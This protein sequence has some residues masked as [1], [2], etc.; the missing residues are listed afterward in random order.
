MFLLN[1]EVNN[2]L[3]PDESNFSLK[4]R[5]KNTNSNKLHFEYVA[6]SAEKLLEKSLVEFAKIRL[7]YE[8]TSMYE[9]QFETGYFDD[10]LVSQTLPDLDIPIDTYLNHAL[11]ESTKYIM[12]GYPITQDI[13]KDHFQY[14]VYNDVVYLRR[15]KLAFDELKTGFVR[16]EYDLQFARQP[17]T[18]QL[19]PIGWYYLEEE[20]ASQ[21]QPHYMVFTK[22]VDPENLT[23][24]DICWQEP[25]KSWV[26]SDLREWFYQQHF[27]SIE[28]ACMY[29][30]KTVHGV[31]GWKNEVVKIVNNVKTK[32]TL[33]EFKNLLND[34]S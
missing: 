26:G 9:H 5:I 23:T 11:K 15:Q 1:K 12:M 19:I 4:G 20:T 22:Y 27:E 2:T 28:Q 33:N 10:W 25:V 31:R 7:G 32:L 14:L 17:K 6:S 30:Q 29:V 24:D 3:T 18:F 21:E 16:I 8:P 34:E 13:L